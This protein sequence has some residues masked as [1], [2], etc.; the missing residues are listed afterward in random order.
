[1]FHVAKSQFVLG[2][3]SQEIPADDNECSLME[4]MQADC[5]D[6]DDNVEAAPV[7]MAVCMDEVKRDYIIDI[8]AFA[9][10]SSFYEMILLQVCHLLLFI[11]FSCIVARPVQNNTFVDARDFLQFVHEYPDQTLQNRTF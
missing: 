2:P 7:A 4:D 6:D 5:E 1:M 9:R 3:L 10:P 11:S 8:F